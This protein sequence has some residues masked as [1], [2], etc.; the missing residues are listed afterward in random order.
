MRLFIM[1]FVSFPD[2]E[3]KN[4]FNKLRLQEN[5]KVDFFLSFFHHVSVFQLQDA[6]DCYHLTLLV[7]VLYRVDAGIMLAHLNLA[8]LSKSML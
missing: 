2:K 5:Y 3:K 7:S 4:R 6:F 8:I 1:I